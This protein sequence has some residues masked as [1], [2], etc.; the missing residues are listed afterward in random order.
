[1]TNSILE[2]EDA[3]LLLCI[4]TNMTESHPV[5]AVRVK[6]ALRKGA[7]L[8]VVDPRRTGLAD[9]AHRFLRLKP[10]S[11]AALFNAMAKAIV[12]AGLV[13]RAFVDARTTGYAELAAHLERFT[14][15]AMEPVTGV[16]A[17]EIRAA[18]LEYAS[19]P[20]AG[21]YYTLGVTE[22][23]GGVA[24]VQALAN[25][26]LLTGNLGRLS[27]GINPLRGQN[28]VQGAGDAGALPNNY[29]GYQK[30]DDP[31]ARAFFEKA[32]GVPLDPER[33]ITKVRALERAIA[34][35]IRAMWIVGENTLASDA[36]AHH[37][38]RALRALD[39][40]VVQ[41]LFLTD[42]ARLA[43]LVLPAAAFAEAEGTFTNTE[44]RVQRVRKAVDPPGQ[45]QPDWW[46]IGELGRRL[47]WPPVRSASEVFDELASVAPIYAGMSHARLEERG[48]QWPC[49]DA[50]HPGTPFLHEGRFPSGRG[51]FR[52]VEPIPPAELPDAE[53]PYLLT[54]GRRLATYHTNTMTGACEGFDVLAPHEAA[55]IHPDDA[56]RL[57]LKTGD[58]MRVR[59]RRGEVR[60]RAR[61][62]DRSPA[63]V[64]FMSFAFPETPVNVLTTRAGDP[65]TETPELKVA[66]VA[67]SREAP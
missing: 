38:E 54:T 1:M 57:G 43:H 67:L 9:R 10:G 64:V 40:L 32:W 62:T 25:L 39:F 47:G 30:V 27:A 63:G 59:S 12:D 44:R 19:A 60:V 8:I 61:V 52:C 23:V 34:G 17:A 13:D 29:P 41:D 21:I 15:E 49:P 51:V 4:G 48:L 50:S 11:D 56:G 37:T 42:T 24:N 14:P 28:N 31:A 22:H 6:R 66:A 46:I 20:R 33:G 55:E 53:Y 7:R 65:V 36:D 45:A 26:A 5:I 16:P 18:A 3:P 2:I 35:D 58:W